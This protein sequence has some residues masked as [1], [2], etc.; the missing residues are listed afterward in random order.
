MK[1]FLHKIDGTIIP[2]AYLSL[3]E[4]CNNAEINYYSAVKG[5]RVFNNIEIVEIII[6]K[7]NKRGKSVLSDRS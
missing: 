1:A 6:I 2:K 7:R 4:L 3:S 5:K